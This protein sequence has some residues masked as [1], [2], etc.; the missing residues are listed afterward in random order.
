MACEFEL[1]GRKCTCKETI[2]IARCKNLCKVHFDTVRKDNLRRFNKGKS[3]PKELVFTRKLQFCETW[4]FLEGKLN[5][6][7]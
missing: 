7:V 3:I 2:G 4:S 1:D 5:R 6:K